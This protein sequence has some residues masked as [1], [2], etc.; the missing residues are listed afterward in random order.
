MRSWILLASL[1]AAACSR[2]A[3]PP[4]P[5][6]PTSTPPRDYEAL[7]RAL[8][9]GETDFEKRWPIEFKVRIVEGLL[10]D[11]QREALDLGTQMGAPYFAD[12]VEL[13][14]ADLGAASAAALADGITVST[15]AVAA[16][17]QASAGEVGERFRRWLSEF[18]FV[19]RAVFKA[20]AAHASDDGGLDATVSIE[21]AGAARGGGLR[22]DAGSAEVRFGKRAGAWR[23]VRFVMRNGETQRAA[24]HMFEDVS[25]AWLARVPAVARATLRTRSRSDELHRVLLDD[26]HAPPA[27]LDHLLPLA[28][29][30]HPGVAVADIDG[31]GFDDLFVWDVQGPAVL[32]HNDGGRGFSEASDQHGLDVADVSAMAFADLDG[33]GALDAVIGHWYSPSEIRFGAGGRFWPGSAG[34]FHLPA[35]VSSISLADIDGDGRLDIYFA[36]AAHDFHIHLAA[37]LD[38]NAAVLSRLDAGERRALTEA[39]PA[40]RAARAAG[41]FDVNTYQFGPRDVVLL[42]RGD[43]RFEDA[44]EALGL[45]QYR[46]TLQAGFADLDGDGAPDLYLAND[47]A[48][49]ALFLQRGGRFVDV[50]APSGADRIFFGMGA[51]FGDFDNDG[52]LDLYAT[53]MQSSAGARIMSDAA[54]FSPEHDQAARRARLDAARGN[55]L[56]RNDGRGAFTDLTATPAFAEARRA[57]WA[58][59]AQ[60]VDVD[61]DGWLDVFSPNG[62]FT[63]SLSPDD[64]FVRDL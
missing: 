60:L 41:S 36:T 64:P 20:K 6:P 47:F 54:N 13:G 37:A 40:A 7:V 9:A 49:A 17:Q 48:P 50:S 5:A 1:C 51:S 4:T 55:T 11:L 33:D 43:G 62:F 15:W 32:L 57:N 14:W 18:R 52:D 28:M 63:S 30:S 10:Q 3:A 12:A 59:S 25:E 53:A 42:N 56:L 2:P 29:D 38:G 8:Y 31:D 21:L 44:T 22:R 61:G 27:S 24:S 19:D 23:I 58:Y 26:K 16:P 35:E 45:V 46:N 39:L 34:R